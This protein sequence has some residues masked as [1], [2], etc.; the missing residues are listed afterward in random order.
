MKDSLDCPINERLIF[1]KQS[2]VY[3]SFREGNSN[4]LQYACLENPRDRG[5]CWAAVYGGRAQ[6]DTTDET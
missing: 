3:H 4:P 2:V 1:K 6:S 5:A